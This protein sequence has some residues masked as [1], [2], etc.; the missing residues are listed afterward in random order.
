MITKWQTLEE[1]EQSP[2]EGWCWVTYLESYNGKTEV[3]IAYFSGIYF[4]YSDNY[5]KN[6]YETYAPDTITHVQPIHKPEAYK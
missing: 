1:F 6:I 4:Y 2:T 3:D 5:D